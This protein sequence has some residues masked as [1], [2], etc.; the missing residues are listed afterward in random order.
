MKEWDFH[1]SKIVAESSQWGYFAF[2]SLSDSY[3]GVFLLSSS[4]DPQEYL[5]TNSVPKKD[6]IEKRIIDKKL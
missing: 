6:S 1:R 5:P 2:S 4:P 3:S